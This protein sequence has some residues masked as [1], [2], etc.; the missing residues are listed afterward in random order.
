MANA[1]RRQGWSAEWKS[2]GVL[3]LVVSL[4]ATPIR[5][6]ELEPPAMVVVRTYTYVNAPLEMVQSARREAQAVLRHAGVDIMWIDCAVKPGD[7]QSDP[8]ACRDLLRANEVMLRIM[9]AK[10]TGAGWQTSLG[11]S[12]IDPNDARP[13]LSTIYLDRVRALAQSARVDG[14]AILGRAIAHELGHLLLRSS[15]HAAEGLMRALW[16]QAELRGREPEHWQFSDREAL[17]IRAAIVTRT[18]SAQLMASR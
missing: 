6:N 5:G 2:A 18:T 11:Y 15:R 16:S 8:A 1:S 12:M 7:R 10:T 13:V 14:S 9:A 17:E 4:F 3:L